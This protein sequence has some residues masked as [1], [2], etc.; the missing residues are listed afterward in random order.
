MLRISKN[1]QLVILSAIFLAF[2]VVALR[3]LDPDFGW[4]LRTGLIILESG[5][6]KLDPY[7]YT[8]PDFPFVD[9]AWGFDTFLAFV[10][11]RSK[12]FVSFVLSALA[13]SAL[14]LSAHITNFVG[15]KKHLPN[16]PS[17]ED[18]KKEGVKLFEQNR[19]LHEKLEEA[20]LY[21]FQL[22]ERMS[23]LEK[24]AEQQN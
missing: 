6:P 16:M 21:I 24:K 5:I 23:K 13:I 2:L 7:S 12:I 11:P 19:L 14:V 22:E 17:T 8:M 20:Y 3:V 10:Y 18:V 1:L 15:T 4:R 9:H